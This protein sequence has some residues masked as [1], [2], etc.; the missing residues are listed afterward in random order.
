[1][2]KIIYKKT[3]NDVLN[4]IKDKKH[5]NFTERKRRYRITVAFCMLS[6]KIPAYL[7]TNV[8]KKMTR[9]EI[10]NYAIQYIKHLCLF[11]E[12]SNKE[13]EMNN[14]QLQRIQNE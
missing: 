7:K 1:M 13:K 9:L 10:L 3:K 14:G 11:L 6:R 2:V 5:R 8:L 12:Q 4:K